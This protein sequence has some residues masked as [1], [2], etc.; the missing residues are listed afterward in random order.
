MSIGQTLKREKAYRTIWMLGVWDRTDW[1]FFD[2]ARVVWSELIFKV[3]PI[4]R[5]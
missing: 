3:K 2:F 4:K 1:M 5:I